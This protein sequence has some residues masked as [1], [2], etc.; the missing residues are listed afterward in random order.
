M[1]E[2]I[3]VNS[4]VG[5][6]NVLFF[7]VVQ[8]F[9]FWFIASREIDRVVLDKAEVLMLLR[10]RLREEKLNETAEALDAIVVSKRRNKE[11]EA[12]EKNRQR[13]QS[14][15]RLV[16]RWIVPCIV[17]VVVVLVGLVWYNHRQHY[18]L[19]YAHKVGLGLVVCAYITEVLFFLTVVS[20]YIMVS[21]SDIVR[22][23]TGLRGVMAHRDES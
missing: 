11:Q 4:I 20:N 21:D 8:I 14:N 22:E 19:Q 10:D 6:S 17:V 7:M 1:P 18:S 3:T 16:Y 13:V 9:F 5:V 23:V 2:H 12:K 15:L